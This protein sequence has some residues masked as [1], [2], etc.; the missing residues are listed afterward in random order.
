M[1]RTKRTYKIFSRRTRDKLEALY[2]AGI[3]VRQ[4]AEELG[5]TLQGIYHELK[6]GYYMHS[7][8]D[9]TETKKYSADKA[10]R[11]ADLNATAKGAPIKLGKDMKF[12]K[13]VEDMILSGYSPEAVLL[14]IKDHNLKFDTEVCRVTLYSYI[15]KG[16]FLRISNKNLLHK[17]NKRKK[18]KKVKTAKQP[19]KENNIEKRP[20]EVLA[21]TTF[22][23]WE[24]DSVIGKRKKGFTLISLTERKTRFQIIL[25]SPNK[26]AA[27]TVLMLNRLERKIGSKNFRKI[28]KTITCDNG[29]EFSNTLGM[30]YSPYTNKQRTTVYYCHPYCSSERGSNENQNG[31]IRRFVPKGSAISEYSNTRLAEIQDFINN[32]PRGIFDGKS[33]M[34][35]FNT[36][37][38]KLNIN[39][40]N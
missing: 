25:K 9:W 15:D 27:S 26:T 22:G 12:A 2:N 3:P 8:H 20:E 17:G 35:L 37:L 34:Q 30:E 39:F 16:I 5:Y 4:I 24:L 6:R 33:S 14:Y 31:F 18:H 19:P 29:V 28:F 1:K 23:H 36:E 11:S 10:Q 7:N 32:Y 40:F 13:F 38:E 21:R